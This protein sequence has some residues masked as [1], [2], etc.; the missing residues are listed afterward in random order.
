[1]T[2]GL[3]LP[4]KLTEQI[5]SFKNASGNVNIDYRTTDSGE[6]SVLG[7]AYTR[8]DSLSNISLDCFP[9]KAT[10]SHISG[11]DKLFK[12]FPIDVVLENIT[13]DQRHY[14]Y[15][16]TD[17]PIVD[18]RYTHTESQRL[19]NVSY[20]YHYYT[21]AG[22]GVTEE[23]FAGKT[24][25]LCV[26]DEQKVSAGLI[27]KRDI[28]AL[29]YKNIETSFSSGLLRATEQVSEIVDNSLE[30][31]PSKVNPVFMGVQSA[32]IKDPTKT[33]TSSKLI[34]IIKEDGT[35]EGPS[36]LT[37]RIP[38]YNLYFTETNTAAITPDA[39]G[40]P[41]KGGEKALFSTTVKNTNSDQIG[42]LSDITLSYTSRFSPSIGKSFACIRVQL[43]EEPYNDTSGNPKRM[44]FSMND[45]KDWVYF[46]SYS[47][48]AEDV[49]KVD[50]PY[51]FK[52]YGIKCYPCEDSTYILQNFT[53]KE[54][55]FV[56]QYDPDFSISTV[57]DREEIIT[58]EGGK[59]AFNEKSFP[60]NYSPC[61]VVLYG[62]E[63]PTEED[64]APEYVEYAL[65]IPPT[66]P[67]ETISTVF[68]DTLVLAVDIDTLITSDRLLYLKESSI[69]VQGLDFSSETVTT[70]LDKFV[71]ILGSLMAN[72]A[73]S[74]SGSEIIVKNKTNT[75]ADFGIQCTG[76]SIKNPEIYL[77]ETLGALTTVLLRGS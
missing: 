14:F 58:D 29:T 52:G 30:V 56:F 19:G 13:G 3:Y 23:S 25:K 42:P 20:M 7:T 26:F 34:A 59:Y 66:Q 68:K 41:L 33:S 36:V 67:N 73:F 49:F 71:S 37:N 10:G 9:L 48:S 12:E 51:Y 47:Q 77:K 45:G 27:G 5:E 74:R 57:T 53:D 28:V 4:L 60:V 64:E 75:W 46:K 38:N 44:R 65:R 69:D 61:R 22:A 62:A 2:L 6:L 54:T 17:A 8:V 24:L 50:F 16:T 35:V 21:F 1:M 43:P 40:F 70:V 72:Y 31:S 76:V 11:Y 55:K 32:I 18:I 39:F 63:E 15:S